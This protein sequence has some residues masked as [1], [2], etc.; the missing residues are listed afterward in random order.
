MCN[1]SRSHGILGGRFGYFFFCSGRG[2]RESEAPGEDRLFIEIPEGGGGGS[3]RGGGLNIFFRGRNVHQVLFGWYVCRTKLTR[4]I[5]LIGKV[6]M[7][8]LKWELTVVSKLITDRHF[9]WEELISNY[10]YRIELPEELISITETDLWEFQQ[11]ISHYRYRFSLE[12]HIISITHT[13]A[14]SELILQ[15]FRLRQ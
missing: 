15:S 14:Q 13:E 4:K 2:E 3:P 7:G 10:R 12:V 6:Y 8:T 11:K 9:F 1:H 5:L